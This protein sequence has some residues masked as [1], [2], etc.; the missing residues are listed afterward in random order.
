M[1]RIVG[2]SNA[3]IVDQNTLCS[4][5]TLVVR[6]SLDRRVINWWMVEAVECVHVGYATDFFGEVV[7]AIKIG[8]RVFQTQFP[9]V[10]LP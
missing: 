10:V 5:L 9:H 7:L 1:L 3:N 2:E 6:V 8:T 4:P